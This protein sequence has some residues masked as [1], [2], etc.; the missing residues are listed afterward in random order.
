[1][2]SKRIAITAALFLLAACGSDSATN[3]I[4]GAISGSLSFNYSGGGGGSFSATGG[5]TSAAIASSPFTT[6]WAAGFKEATDNSTNIAA[7]IPR[8]S[9]TS[10][11]TAITVKGQSTGTFNI[12]VNCLATS[13]ST[14]ND[15]TLFIAQSAGGQTF[16]YACSFT[17]G[18]ITVS[19]LSSTSA[20]G[21]FSGSGVCFTPTGANSAFVVTNGTFNV[22][23]LVN[24]PGTI[25]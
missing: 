5:I 11:L 2:N 7:N 13:V 19:T 1:M 16:S 4:N 8:T 22:P 14:C 9:T 6:T 25:R 23:L 12:D 20:V 3:A 17:S 21:I 24:V 15:V 18:S 10:D